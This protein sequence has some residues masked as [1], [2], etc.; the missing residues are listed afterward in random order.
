MSGYKI[1]PVAGLHD[2]TTGALVGF[3]GADGKEYLLPVSGAYAA[4]GNINGKPVAASTLSASSTVSGAGFSAYLA[5]PPAIGGTTP[6]AVK[7]SDLQATYTNSAATPGNVTNNS[8]RGKAAFAAAGSSV[9]VTSSLV[10]AASTVLCALETADAT[11]T[12]ILRATPTAGSFTV[13]G[14]AAATATT[15][16]SFQVIN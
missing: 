14:N 13:T 1:L 15:T 8:P 4:D 3:L 16:F 2:A 6:A 10:T 12:Q 11:L 5:A 7:T 9:T